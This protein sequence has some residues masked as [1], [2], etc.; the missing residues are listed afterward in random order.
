RILKRPSILIIGGYDT[1]NLPEIGYG[2]QRGGVKR[3]IARATMNF[4]SSIVTHSSYARDE[5]IHNAGIDPSKIAAIHLGFAADLPCSIRKENTAITVGN[6]DRDNLQRKGLEPFVRAAALLSDVPFVLIGA[7]RDDAIERLRSFA[8]ANVQFTGR[9]D[10]AALSAFLARAR[11]YVQASRHEAFGMAL[12]EAMLSECVPV[13][14]RV[15]ALPEVVGE[16]GIYIDSAEPQI[17]AEGIRRA[18]TC[19]D[20][21]GKRARTRIINEFPLERRRKGLY[22][23]MEKTL[24]QHG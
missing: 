9:L 10:D 5:A 3:W 16:T 7:W 17:V 12:A 1:A 14:T 13:V 22:S 15:G 11:V 6:V 23:V 24:E 8:P 19:D 2:S 4:A 20:G 21:W 18:I